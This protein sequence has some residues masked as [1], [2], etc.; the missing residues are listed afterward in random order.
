MKNDEKVLRQFQK[1][2]K[3]WPDITRNDKR[4]SYKRFT[5][6]DNQEDQSWESK[7]NFVCILS[8]YFCG[9]M[10][11]RTQPGTLQTAF[12]KISY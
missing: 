1:I 3:S 7:T 10:K 4:A 12:K 6:D 8:L 2:F 9:N 11:T 5:K